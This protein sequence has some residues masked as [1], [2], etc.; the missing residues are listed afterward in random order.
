MTMRDAVDV[1]RWGAHLGLIYLFISLVNAHEALAYKNN[2]DGMLEIY[3]YKTFWITLEIEKK[4]QNP[5]LE[6]SMNQIDNSLEVW[7]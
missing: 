4:I 3:L 1:C 7:Q 5:K 6:F 2:Y